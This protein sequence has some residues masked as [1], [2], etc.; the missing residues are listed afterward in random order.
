MIVECSQC[1]TKYN[2]DDNKIPLL[3]V[4]VRCRQCQNIIF[5]KTSKQ[6]RTDRDTNNEELSN[7]EI[8]QAKHQDIKKVYLFF[9]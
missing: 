3:G 4:K 6:S 9:R 1:H 8:I 7:N 2:V 5:I